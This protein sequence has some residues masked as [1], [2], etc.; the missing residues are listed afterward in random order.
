MI[1]TTATTHSQCSPHIIT[2]QGYAQVSQ[3]D[4]DQLDVEE[5]EEA[6]LLDDPQSAADT[7]PLDPTNNTKSKRRQQPK[8]KK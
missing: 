3:S 1:G 4:D 8:K 7:Q 5:G 6:D 2:N